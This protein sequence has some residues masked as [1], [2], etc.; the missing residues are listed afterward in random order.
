LFKA[1]RRVGARSRRQ[2]SRRCAEVP[3]ADHREE[4]PD[5]WDDVLPS[6]RLL[7]SRAEQVG[8]LLP[9]EAE[10][11]R[12]IYLEDLP[13]RE[14]APGEPYD[15]INQRRHRALCRLKAFA[16]KDCPGAVTN[17]DDEWGL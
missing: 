9:D 13:L 10:L 14:A 6:A 15:R 8:A 2:A 17:P 12:R 1:W 11:I 4:A 5:I 16:T 3:L 7:I